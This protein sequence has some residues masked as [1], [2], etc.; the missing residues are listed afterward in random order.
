M[1]TLTIR[2]NPFVNQVVCFG[3][4]VAKPIVEEIFDGRNPFVNQVVCFPTQKKNLNE[5]ILIVAIP[6]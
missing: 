1:P 5:Q 4:G 6:S 3:G 2:R